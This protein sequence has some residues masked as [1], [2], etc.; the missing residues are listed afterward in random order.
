MCVTLLGSRARVCKPKIMWKRIVAV[1]LMLLILLGGIVVLFPDAT[2]ERLIALERGRAGLSEQRI[3]AGGWN[4]PYLVGGPEDAPVIVMVHGFSADK[5]N[6]TRFAAHFTGDY[7]VIAPDLPGFGEQP[8]R[9]GEDYRL[10]AQVERLRAFIEALGLESVHMVGNSMGGHITALYALRYPA[11]LRSAGLF[12]NAG[13]VSPEMPDMARQ[14]QRG[15]NPLL[16]DSQED[17]A[18]VL[19]YTMEQPPVIPW[20][21][22]P[23]LARQ[24]LA[25]RGSNAAIFEQYKTDRASALDDRFADIQP[26]VLVLWGR[27]DRVLDVSAVEVMARHRP[28]TLTVILEDTGHLPMIE[29]P[30][31]SAAAYRAFLR[32]A[33]DGEP[34]PQ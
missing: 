17:F 32:G 12:N 14:L 20:P 26:P 13:I 18:R 3:D 11:A 22:Q 6:W 34:Q 30:A 2:A 8:Y 1:A 16:V 15:V 23:Y 5:D 28:E 19:R 9:D 4:W 33:T 24:A 10:A 21:V 25:K 7:R 27:Q 29:R 31:E